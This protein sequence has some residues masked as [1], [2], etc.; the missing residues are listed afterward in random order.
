MISFFWLQ[1]H[2][3]IEI[4]NF[5]YLFYPQNIISATHEKNPDIRFYSYRLSLYNYRIVHFNKHN[6]LLNKYGQD[7]FDIQYRRVNKIQLNLKNFYYLDVFIIFIDNKLRQSKRAKN[8]LG[9]I[10]IFYQLNK[11]QIKPLIIV[12]N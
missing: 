11:N 3:S 8:Y 2:I 10:T 7:F 12:S 4:N 9:P 1:S 6:D 5:L